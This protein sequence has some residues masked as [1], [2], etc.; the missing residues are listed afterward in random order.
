[1]TKKGISMNDFME[2]VRNILAVVTLVLIA[3][4]LHI[5]MNGDKNKNRFL[6]VLVCIKQAAMLIASTTFVVLIIQIIHV[7]GFS[8]SHQVMGSLGIISIGLSL[9]NR[10]CELKLKYELGLIALEERIKQKG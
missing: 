5:D 7:Y 1:M 8:G 2:A 3:I 6:K 4:Y 9:L 10:L